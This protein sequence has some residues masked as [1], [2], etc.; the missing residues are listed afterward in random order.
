V[1]EPDRLTVR[2]HFLYLVSSYSMF[3]PNFLFDEGLNDEL[4]EPQLSTILS[5]TI[6]ENKRR[7]KLKIIRLT[8]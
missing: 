5:A 2:Q 8:L 3:L 7:P 1:P 4:V 6:Q